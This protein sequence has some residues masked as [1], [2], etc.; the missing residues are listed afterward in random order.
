MNVSCKMRR[1]LTFFC[2]KDVG[3]VDSP[4]QPLAKLPLLVLM[5]MVSSCG[6]CPVAWMVAF[7][8]LLVAVAYCGAV[9]QRTVHQHHQPSQQA[10]ARAAP[11]VYPR[12]LNGFPSP[13]HQLDMQRRRG[14]PTH[15]TLRHDPQQQQHDH[16]RHS[17]DATTSTTTPFLLGAAAYTV[18]WVANLTVTTFDNFTLHADC[19]VPTNGSSEERFPLI[20]LPNSW[21][22]YE[23]EYLGKTLEWGS[24][25]YI[26]CEYQSRGWFASTGLADVGGRLDQRD[27]STMIDAMFAFARQ[28]GWRLNESSVGF[29][30]ISYGAG[31]SLMAAGVDARVSAVVSL[32]GWSNLSRALYDQETPSLA[33]GSI[34]MW[35]SSLVGR[36]IPEL[37]LMWRDM[38]DHHNVSRLHQF[39]DI[40]S[41]EVHLPA[42][43]DRKVAIMLSNNYLDRL[44]RPQHLLDFWTL[45]RG[46]RFML[47]NQGLH[48]EPESK[49]LPYGKDNVIWKTA[50][51][52][53]DRYLKN[54]H[55]NGIDSEPPVQMQVHGTNDYVRFASFPDPNMTQFLSF[56][57]TTRPANGSSPFGGLSP[58]QTQQSNRQ[59]IGNAAATAT[60]TVG[61]DAI[62][63]STNPG[64]WSG[65]AVIADSNDENYNISVTT[66]LLLVPQSTSMVYVTPSPL[67]N[68]V[69]LCGTAF[70]NMTMTA[71]LPQWQ[72]YGYLYEVDEWDIGTLI[73]DSYWTC[74][75]NCP[76]PG[77]TL[78][79]RTICRA[80]SKGSRIAVGIT[81]YDNLYEP[82]CNRSALLVNMTGAAVGTATFT[83]PVLKRAP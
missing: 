3:Q 21:A 45:L 66:E 23:L 47:L 24:R 26:M 30:G 40:R 6:S 52:W 32:S 29:M 5:P 58:V 25:G 42:I 15:R 13:H 78:E 33:Y 1:G 19:V 2:V 46:P 68:D 34:L 60:T 80:I 18:E 43:N 11:L 69:F 70:F 38:L 44:F 9:S 63:F 39:C 61:V 48:A 4:H 59:S 35:L 55:A 74:W 20:I 49:S 75:D 7:A 8:L 81:L 79:F 14:S 22:A 54:N 17:R 77:Q 73:A 82:A 57:V 56:T 65:E 76:R 71:N 53:M 50:Q 16:R 51:R 28:R 67:R 41:P 62:S 64:C 83:V 72:T 31:L 27:L 36:P 10:A 37:E 12:H